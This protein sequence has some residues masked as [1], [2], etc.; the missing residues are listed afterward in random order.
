MHV[1]LMEPDI[2][3]LSKTL[4]VLC[5]VNVLYVSENTGI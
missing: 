4:Y 3:F 5:V 2:Q 1:L